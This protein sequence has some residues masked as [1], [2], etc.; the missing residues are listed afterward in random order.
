MVV[1]VAHLAAEMDLPSRSHALIESVNNDL[2]RLRL[3]E[4]N[5]GDAVGVGAA[6]IGRI[7]SQGTWR[8]SVSTTSGK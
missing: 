4:G 6:C 2:A 1:R 3:L 7:K 8:M 5:F